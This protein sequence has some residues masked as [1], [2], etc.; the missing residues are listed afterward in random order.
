ML[1]PT[2]LKRFE[3]WL[4][5][6]ART[7]S[8][9]LPWINNP[10]DVDYVFYVTDR[11]NTLQLVEL[12][13]LRP[14]DECWFVAELHNLNCTRLYAY[15]YPF[16]RPLFGTEFPKYD[17]FEHVN[18]YKQVL[19]NQGLARQCIDGSKFWYHV[20][21]GIYML[22]NET[23]ELTD[24]Q[25]KNINLC[26]DRQITKDIYNYIQKRLRAYKDELNNLK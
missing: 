18:E 3:P 26:H 19:I 23:Y 9:I 15:E 2:E 17:L 6:V 25:I 21:T 24:E 14:K 4:L 8:T 7:G 11:R 1:T 13:N 20:L 10:H 22:D 12:L 16:M 5:S